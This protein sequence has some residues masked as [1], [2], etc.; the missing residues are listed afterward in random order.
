MDTR[1]SSREC[2]RSKGKTNTSIIINNRM[3]DTV[4]FMDLVV[5]LMYGTRMIW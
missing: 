3:H 2:P 5:V 4:T 1:R